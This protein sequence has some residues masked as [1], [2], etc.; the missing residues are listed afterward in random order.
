MDALPALFQVLQE[1]KALQIVPYIFIRNI[2]LQERLA[3]RGTVLSTSRDFVHV[4]VDILGDEM[5]HFL[6][7]DMYY[8]VS[9]GLDVL[10]TPELSFEGDPD[11]AIGLGQEILIVLE[12]DNT[13]ERWC[14]YDEYLQSLPI[15]SEFYSE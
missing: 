3:Y 13:A 1:L 10:G 9:P 4:S 14:Y 12:M 5:D 15:G 11:T 8:R 2:N 6:R 7:R